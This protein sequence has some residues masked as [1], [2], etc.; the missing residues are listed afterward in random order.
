[1]NRMFTNFGAAKPGKEVQAQLFSKLADLLATGFSLNQSLNFVTQTHRRLAPIT[2]QITEALQKGASVGESMRPFVSNEVLDQLIIAEQ[3]GRL[4]QTLAQLAEFNQQRLEQGKKLRALL[5]Y[6]VILIV[7]LAILLVVIYQVVLPQVNGLNGGA[8]YDGHSIR[9]V[10]PVITILI[11]I[12]LVIWWLRRLNAVHRFNILVRLPL[13]GKIVRQY[14]N[15][16]LANNLATLLGNGLNGLDI[17][18]VIQQ[19]DKRSLI[20]ELGNEVAQYLHAGDGYSATLYRYSFVTPELIS[21]L[22]SGETVAETANLMAAYA[23]LLFKNIVRESNKL[24]AMVQPTI[25]I[26]IGIV[27]TSAYLQILLPIYDSIRRMY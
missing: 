3:H 22:N 14:V 9:S 17:V 2:I 7:V 20:Y 1:M 18:K 5:V 11:T 15:Y 19:F 13:V 4:Q 26:V 6:P 23:Q 27:V 12:L 21:L 10:V 25:F 24:I 8:G 16:Y